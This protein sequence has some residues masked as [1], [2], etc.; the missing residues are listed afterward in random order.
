MTSVNSQGLPFTAGILVFTYPLDY[1]DFNLFKIY[2]HVDSPSTM[3][4]TCM[5]V[6]YIF[7]YI[8]QQQR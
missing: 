4:S 5:G 6:I 8:K 3:G 2:P 7:K 1:H